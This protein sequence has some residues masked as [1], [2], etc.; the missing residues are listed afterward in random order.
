M[1]CREVL[2]SRCNPTAKH[3]LTRTKNLIA[4]IRFNDHARTVSVRDHPIA[5]REV[6]NR[7]SAITPYATRMSDARLRYVHVG[8]VRPRRRDGRIATNSRRRIGVVLVV[9][10]LLFPV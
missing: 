10:S 8:D 4:S 5:V 9:R 2:L 1:L 3:S 7:Y 6:S